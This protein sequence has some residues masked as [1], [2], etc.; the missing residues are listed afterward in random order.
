MNCPECK[1]LMEIEPRQVRLG[2]STCCKERDGYGKKC[3][4]NGHRNY[5]CNKCLIVARRVSPR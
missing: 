2:D 3:K 4:Q 1:Q 5:T